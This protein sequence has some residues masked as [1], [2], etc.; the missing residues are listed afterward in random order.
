MGITFEKLSENDLRET[1][2]MC[3]RAFGED[4][5]FDGVTKV[6]HKCKDD[7]HYHFI[8]GKL[9][10]KVVAYT[11]MVIFY[12]LF[13]GDEPIA[14]LWYV[15]VDESC[16]RQGAATAMFRHIRE[17]AM[18]NGCEIIYLTANRDNVGAHRFYRS[19]G[20][21][22]EREKAFVKYLYEEY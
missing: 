15:C 20:Y 8:V 6:F 12:N 4:N 19:V 21:T 5:S 3:M 13:D 7:S 1:Y 17:I 2:E 11:T 14:A 9:D 16:R 18:A 10:G 22:D